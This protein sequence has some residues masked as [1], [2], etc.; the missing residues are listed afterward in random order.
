MNSVRSKW[1]LS[2]KIKQNLNL[3]LVLKILQI[4]SQSQGHIATDGQSVCLS[5][6]RAPSGAHDQILVTV[7]Q[8]LSC[9]WEGALSD[10]RTGLPFVRV[11]Q[12]YYVN[13]HYIQFLHFTCF[14]SYWIHMEYIQGLCQSGL[15]TTD[16]ALFLVTFA[17]TTQS[18]HLNDRMLDRRQV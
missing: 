18:S 5:W 2:Q 14:I 12:Q 9:P 15:S 1:N 16:Y 17:R 6:C 10:E 3:P 7:W 4:Y 13:C 8:L 11:S